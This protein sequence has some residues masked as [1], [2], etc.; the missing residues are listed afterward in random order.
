MID[1]RDMKHEIIET[2]EFCPGKISR[3]GYWVVYRV[4]GA[5]SFMQALPAP[6][7]TCRPENLPNF[8]WEIKSTSFRD[9]MN[10]SCV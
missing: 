1:T 7:R 9:G 6:L 3:G 10:G 4:E 2:G 8:T 5:G